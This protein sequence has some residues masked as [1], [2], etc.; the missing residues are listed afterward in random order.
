MWLYSNILF[1]SIKHITLTQNCDLTTWI[2]SY[3][4]KLGNGSL[5]PSSLSVVTEICS[6][7]VLSTVH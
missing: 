5:E 1:Q 3:D 4:T 7:E 2:S 6:R